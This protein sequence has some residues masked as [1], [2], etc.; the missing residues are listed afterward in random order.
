MRSQICFLAIAATG[1]AAGIPEARAQDAGYPSKTI[2]WVVPHPAGA[3]FDVVGRRIVQSLAVRLGVPVIVENK[4]GANAA[5]AASEVAREKPD[6]YTYL[7][8]I[9]DSLVGTPFLNKV[10][11]DPLRD[12]TLIGKLV[13]NGAM[14]LIHSNH[15]SNNLRELVDEA[16]SVKEGMTYGSF[17]H[18]TFPHVVMEAFGKQAG[19]EFRQIPYKG[20][21]FVMQDFLADRVALAFNSAP[22]A[23]PLIAKGQIKALAYINTKR[24]PV[25][26]NVPTFTEAG[27][28]NFFGRNA[29]WCGLVAP[30]GLPAAIVARIG[31]AVNATLRDPELVR[32]LA[33][34]DFEV[35]AGTGAEF[36]KELREEIPTV[37]KFMS[38]VGIKPQ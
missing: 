35:V 27:F 5:L 20:S 17:G 31:N 18:G 1:M 30:R 21:V 38:E 11:Y 8:A 28:D 12:F 13:T 33:E 22:F 26:P 16:K 19:I 25:L 9:A 37:T 34:Q 2:R 6:G 10:S 23:A 15:K 32:W 7:Q 29:N 4:A 14:L 24:S 36:E 3:P